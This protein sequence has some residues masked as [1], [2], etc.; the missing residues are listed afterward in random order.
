MA[1]NPE[2]LL[3]AAYTDSRIFDLRV[4]GAGFAEVTPEKHLRGG[5]TGR[6]SARLLDARARHAN[7]RARRVAP[8]AVLRIDPVHGVQVLNEPHQLLA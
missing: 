3:A 2:R 7:P 1:N 8:L 5:P 4:P 6:E